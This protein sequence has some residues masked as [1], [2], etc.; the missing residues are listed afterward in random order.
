MFLNHPLLKKDV[1]EEREYQVN[2]AKSSLMGNTLVVLPT[3][4]G[5]TVIGIL[6]M[7]EVLYRRGGKVIFLAPTKP[8]VEQHAK[9]I[10]ALTKIEDVTV[11]TGEI[12]KKKRRE[13][14]KDAKVIVSTP[15]VIQNDLL[16]GDISLEDVNLII[17]DEA[18][19]AVGN[20]AY[21][22]IAKEYRK[23]DEHLLMGLTASP[24][25][26]EEKINEI[27]ENL[28]IENV[29]IRTEDDEDVKKYI[30]GFEI[31]TV[32]LPMPKE[33][34]ELYGELKNLYDE[35]ISDL[36]KFGLFITVRKVSR[37]DILNAQKMV[38]EKIHDG[39][40]EYYQVAMLLNMAIKIDYAIEYL[41]TQGFEA[42]HKYLMKLVDEG[43]SRGGSKASRNLVRN[44]KFVNCIRIDRELTRKIKEIENPK[45]NAL[46]VILRKQLA[47]NPDSRIIIFTHYRETAMLVYERLKDVSNVRAVRFVGQATKGEDKGLKQKEQVEIIKKFRKGEYNVLIATSVAEEGLDIPTT[48]MVI[49]YEPVPSE[50]RSIQRRG[51]TGRTQIGKVI[52]LATKGTRDVAYLWSS[53]NKEKRMKNELK[54]LK[55]LLRDKVKKM[56]R[57][58]IWGEEKRKV[59]EKGQ[60]TLMDFEEE[61]KLKVYVDN[62][63]FRSEVVRLLA[64][65][66]RII[67]QQLEV[68]DYVISDRIVIE[69]KTTD[70]FLQSIKDGRL[71]EQL[72]NMRENYS[73]PVLIVEGDSLFSRGFHKNAVYGA[74]ASIIGDFSIPIIFTKDGNETASIISALAKREFSEGR[75]IALRK[76]KKIM[77]KDERIRY[78]VESLPNISATLA[79]RLLEHFGS[80]KEIV[81]ADVG[82][83][84]QVKG[85]G[86]KTAEE[87]HEIVNEKYK[88]EKTL[89]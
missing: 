72:K 79:K 9:T 34:E 19:R 52:I 38:Q 13:K 37:R 29:E 73:N 4:L 71:F 67:P 24:G 23:K 22:Y 18:H 47:S 54:W 42:C 64:D 75:E 8:L 11:F 16:S 36:K 49:F 63:E 81:N 17:F 84:M 5:K 80:V 35:I 55:I 21:V 40:S 20:Y 77:G 59:K 33:V 32:S 60:L 56:K 70:D 58:D 86:R 89:K 39:K 10:K 12:S 83:L 88:G 7:V 14:W 50:V 25:S 48:D 2:I 46:R 43:N 78:I 65:E 68:G 61:R 15:Q 45:L 57:R 27:I 74:L 69:R 30:K 85:I 66:F 82:E 6:A 87:I 41:E 51:R 31:R 44:E 1:V 3:A 26:N 53:R 28:G 76:G 62:R